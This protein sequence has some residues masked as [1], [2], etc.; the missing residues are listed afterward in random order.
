M[1]TA[2]T[3]ACFDFPSHYDIV[4]LLLYYNKSTAPALRYR[5]RIRNGESEWARCGNGAVRGRLLPAP[6]ALFFS[7][8][9]L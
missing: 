6:R 5:V 4:K 1:E 8:G 7:R 3:L 9:L 2:L